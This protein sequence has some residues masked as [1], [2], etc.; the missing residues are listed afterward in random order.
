MVLNSGTGEAEAKS[1]VVSENIKPMTT[2][3]REQIVRS[4]LFPL[5]TTKSGD[6]VT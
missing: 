2:D 1:L 3:L 5:M 4:K 6:G